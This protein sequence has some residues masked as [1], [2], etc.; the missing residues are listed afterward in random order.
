MVEPLLPCF[1]EL[2]TR[3]VKRQVIGEALSLERRIVNARQDPPAGRIVFDLVEQ[4][5][6]GRLR[7][8]GNFGNSADFLIPIRALHHSELTERFDPIKPAAQIA[9]EHSYLL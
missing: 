2:V 4:H 1:D 7:S 9:I 8:C 5:R 6:R 3:I